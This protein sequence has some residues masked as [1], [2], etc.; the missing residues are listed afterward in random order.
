MRKILIVLGL[1]LITASSVQ[2][3]GHLI[4][5]ERKFTPLV[6]TAHQVSVTIDEQVAVTK[7]DQTFHNNNSRQLEAE[8]I[9]PVPKGAN[10]RR[11]SMWVNG[12]EVPGE[13][14]EADKAR[15]IYTDIVRRTLDPGLLEYMN[16]SLFKL[17]VFPVL[18]NADQKISISYTSVAPSD[19]GLIEY[20]YPLRTDARA[21]ANQ[22]RFSLNVQ[23]KSQHPLEN[24]YSPSHAIT[25]S[26]PNDR[27]ATITFAQNQAVM[28][29]DFQLF[30]TIST[31][32]VGLNML[33]HR[34]SANQDGYFMLLVSP[35]A[36]LSKTQ[37]IPRDM[38]FVLDTSGSMHGKRIVQA[39]NALKFCL[40]NLNSH[41]RFGLMNFATTVNMYNQ[42]L[43]PATTENLQ[44]ASKW[45]DRLEATGG[46]AIDLALATALDMRTGDAG[47][48]FTI[49]FFTDGQPTIGE[50]NTHTILEHVAKR[51]TAETRIF[52]FGVGDDVNAS[53]LDA[54]S[55][56]SRGYASY[57]RESEDIEAKVSGL[58]SKISN[59]VLANLKLS[60]DGVTLSDV[61]PPQL[62]DLFHGTQLVVLGRYNGKGKTAVQLTGSVGSEKKVFNYDVTFP[63]QTA[64]DKP[65]VEDLWARRKVGYMLDQIRVNGAKK[66]LVDEVVT[67]AKRY[68]ITTPY[69]SYLVVP[70]G[71]MPIV[72]PAWRNPV[73]FPR[74]VPLGLAPA[75]GAAP[76]A[77]P[78][79]VEEFARRMQFNAKGDVA[80]ARNQ[81]DQQQLRD[82]LDRAKDGK[83]SADEKKAVVTALKQVKEAEALSTA[84]AIAG[85]EL[86]RNNLGAVQAGQLGVTISQY[87]FNL[88]NQAQV[89]RNASQIANN[90][91]VM[92]I[93]G[94]WIDEGY[95]KQAPTVKTDVVNVKAMS[96]A[97]F[98]I[99]EKQ[100]SMRSVFQLGN[101]LLWIT[102]SGRALVIDLNAGQEEMPDAD[103][104]RLFV[105]Q[106]K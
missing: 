91:N 55:E 42:G 86:S 72:H 38:V 71:P 29:R 50:T 41:D 93:G 58:Y 16:S 78:A 24:I 80:N 34:P 76:G 11:F 74:P 30:Y 3:Q 6:M 60:V 104:D 36:E 85:K 52:S 96:N 103:I 61:Y 47:R 102:P 26:R 69:T 59:P 5:I 28:D 82:L 51:N 14:V 89:T 20:V 8:Y 4:P 44:T 57:V 48:P 79:H 21:F 90:R 15:Q 88:R 100:P 46:T 49:V 62:P 70:D 40:Q 9:F 65:F 43:L 54:L 73:P 95:L 84:N 92:D 45:V 106:R 37:Q 10:V 12:A 25:M 19:N 2:A 99:L 33:T 22:D 64:E 83:A 27:Q 63:E 66:E 94:V 56:K 68:G 13:L 98:R 75:P 1:A 97:Y 39:R 7:I 53:F 87:S 32:D 18:P 23:L 67:L 17:R 101:H 105:A 31:K 35:R 81:M 77:A